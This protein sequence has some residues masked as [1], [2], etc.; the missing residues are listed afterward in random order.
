MTWR[1]VRIIFAREIRDQ[2]RDRR[3]I[4]MVAVLPVF[5]Y[6]LLGLSFFQIAQFM[7]EKP[8]RILVIGARE[9][10]D[11]PL[12]ENNR[13][14]EMFFASP[15]E[16][17]LLE[18]TFFREEPED[19]GLLRAPEGWETLAKEAITSQDFDAVL[20]FPP[21]FAG[22]L[23]RFR[24]E[25]RRQ[26][27]AHFPGDIRNPADT[28]FESTGSKDHDELSHS[29][30][31]PAGKGQPVIVARSAIPSP[32]I[33]YSSAQERSQTAYNRLQRVLEQWSTQVMIANLAAAQLP[34]E[35]A[36]P[37]RLEIA[38]VSAGTSLQG[39]AVWAKIFPVLLVIWSLTGSFY[40]AVD[41]CAGEKERGTL[42]T[43]LSSPA[44]RK[45]IVLGKLAAITLFSMATA[46]L[47]LVSMG[48]TGWLAF[49]NLPQFSAPPL[50][51]VLWL[52]LA[53]LPTSAA[54]SC[55]ALG[56]AAFARST[57]EGQ[58]YLMPLLFVTLPLVGL[59]MARGLELDLG[60]ALIPIT[61]LVLLLKTLIEGQIAEALRFV[62]PVTAVT[63]GGC[64][65]MLRWSVQQFN[66][67][68]VLFRES[69]RFDLTAW[70][71]YAT[72]R[73][74][75]PT[76]AL[77]LLCGVSILL[78]RFVLT[79]ALA[80]TSLTLS[81]MQQ[82]LI[83]QLVVVLLP[84]GVMTGLFV[85]RPRETLL[86]RWP[87]WRHVLGA[88]LLAVALCPAFSTFKLWV[89]KLYPLDPAIAEYLK[90]LSTSVPDWPTLLFV[91]ALVPA[92]CEELAFRGFVL[93]GFR[94][95]LRPLEAVVYSAVFFALTHALMQQ[96]VVAFVAGLVLGMLALRTGSLYPCVVYHAMHN[97]LGLVLGSITAEVY[98]QHPWL[99]SLASWTEDGL[100]FRGPIVAAG[101]LAA[102]LIVSWMIPHSPDRP[103]PEHDA[104]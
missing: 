28:H 44:S 52:G 85:D 24:E 59:P 67:E 49:G 58:Y 18:L 83:T 51:S 14:C 26:L 3:T 78:V 74:S 45:E 64:L 47:N 6:P 21:G 20:V 94:S 39:A 57:K 29:G 97:G 86:L 62:A 10:L 95:G 1:N 77:A 13:F 43:L 104:D 34:P 19:H 30:E 17:R 73:R 69:E 7:G 102:G 53:L 37:F 61:G 31:P 81:F 16:A 75:V 12:F 66:R 79:Q 93:S 56:I 60:T 9:P 100:M 103:T 88:A 54:F 84:V 32:Q 72:R 48:L 25:I 4:F 55:L 99:E 36:R 40:P 15:A 5:L 92:V 11:P 23:A 96:S 42:E 87:R 63:L 27:T 90:Q 70:L 33:Y 35:A 41:L 76:P 8:S 38:D 89:T 91:M 22:E 68:Q 46:V 71:R 82:A 101:I 65:L 80:R 98:R 50:S 2:L